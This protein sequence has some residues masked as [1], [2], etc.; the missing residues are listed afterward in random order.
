MPV[1]NSF[2]NNNNVIQIIRS[3]SSN[4]EDNY[5]K[6]N[7]MNK[8]EE[9]IEIIFA[10]TTKKLNFPIKANINEKLVEVIERFKKTICPWLTK[11]FSNPIYKQQNINQMKTLYE[12]GIKNGDTIEFTNSSNNNKNNN[13]IIINN[14][15]KKNNYN[16][17]INQNFF[18]NNKVNNKYNNFNPIR[19]NNLDD[20]EFNKL[21]NFQH[22]KSSVISDILPINILGNDEINIMQHEHKLVYCITLSDWKCNICYKNFKK[23]KAKYYCSVCDFNICVKCYKGNK[24]IPEPIYF[25]T[26]L[27]HFVFE[28][29]FFQYRNHEHILTFCK[30]VVSDCSGWSCNKCKKSYTY[31]EWS[32]YCSK[33]DYDICL[34]CIKENLNLI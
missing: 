11:S 28:A 10:H 31:D 9:N 18:I 13:N 34:I 12:I 24:F 29:K 21:I 25:D 14:F 8:L 26:N 19:E 20:N 7:Y 16:N 5:V 4:I 1:D 15:G 32:F 33:C 30:R 17:N 3:N 2:L 22:S 23:I 27:P 6:L